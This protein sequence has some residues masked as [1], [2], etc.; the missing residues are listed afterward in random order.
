MSTHFN[1]AL[2]FWCAFGLCAIN[3]HLFAIR[4][5]KKVVQDE[6]VAV[7]KIMSLPKSARQQC[8]I[9]DNTTHA[10]INA[11]HNE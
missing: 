2:T 9:W 8:A 6:E 4:C 3:C 1:Q 5:F 10:D 7:E 11:P